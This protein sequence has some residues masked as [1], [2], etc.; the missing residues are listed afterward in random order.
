MADGFKIAD[1]Y[2][3]VEARLDRAAFQRHL[4][5]VTVKVSPKV[6]TK[7]KNGLGKE[8][9]K[10]MLSGIGDAFA[11]G[12]T[13]TITAGLAGTGSL[14]SALSS[15]PYVAAAGIALAVGIVAVAAPA[16]GAGLA[17]ALAAGAGLGV[18]AGG[19]LLIKD[20]PLVKKAAGELG[21]TLFDVDTEEIKTRYKAAQDA[22]TAALRSGNRDRI[23]EARANLAAVQKELTK[24]EEFNRKNFS[25]KDAAGPLIQPV[26]NSLKIFQDAAQ[27]IIPKIGEMFA[28]LDP[29]IEPL[30]QGLVG[31]VE[32]ALP[33]FQKLIEASVPILGV[34]AEHL[35]ILGEAFSMFF[36]DVAGGEEG[37]SQ[38]LGDFLKWL[39]GFIVMTGK[40]IMWLSKAYVYVRAFFVRDIPK[41]ARAAWDWFGRL[42]DKVSGFFSGI[43]NWVT[44]TGSSIGDWFTNLV[45]KVSDFVTGVGTWLA[46]LPGRIG[47]W[48]A[49]L[50]G[51]IAKWFTDAWHRAWYLVGYYGGLIFTFFRDL[52]GKVWTFLSSLPDKIGAIWTSMW[53]FV[54]TK[55]TEWWNATV[56]WLSALPGKIG[57]F[58]Q[59]VWNSVTTWVKNTWSSATTWVSKTVNDVV[60]WFKGLPQK[61]K[62]ALSS[63]KTKVMEVLSSAGSW[64]VNTGE[65]II[66]GLIQGIKDK[67]GALKGVIS[68]IVSDIKQGFKDAL[69]IGSPSRLMADEVGRW[70]PPGIG[71]GAEKAMP[72][73]LD[74]LRGLVP[75][76]AASVAPGGTG[77]VTGSLRE[78]A[79]IIIQNLNI[80][81][82]WDFT[83]PAEIRR[84][85][86]RL[87]DELNR[88][89]KGYAR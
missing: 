73:L 66:N 31:L 70:I 43:W 87:Y 22:L 26:V 79:Q 50:P 76:M 49:S 16:I 74:S 45:T 25:L 71:Q 13:K 12:F 41:W 75:D 85:I 46:A 3:E 38:F 88:Y 82:V 8:V 61:A 21:R 42:W 10:G 2:V 89:E 56:A 40:L 24:A 60:T 5:D 36:S 44:S 59:G 63:L 54:S 53:T 1:A 72:S 19:I 68:G 80:R 83:D 64:L 81:G 30:A 18:I 48:L 4:E 23:K 15:N 28:T 77:Q 34:L 51:A 17:A 69:K 7:V 29:A 9:G 11:T 20:D 35:P 47:T 65:Q 78:R 86:A 57:S 67:I 6:E 52:P 32:K 62:D 37:A 14:A 55:A 58:F 27:R 84:L 33:G 39:A